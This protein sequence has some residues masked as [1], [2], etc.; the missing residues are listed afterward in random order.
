MNLVLQ[1]VATA[2]AIVFVVAVIGKV[3]AWASWTSLVRRFPARWPLIQTIRFGVPA[4]EAAVVVGLFTGAP[5]SLFGAA[6]LLV[7][8]A[9]GVA[10][11][12]SVIGHEKCNCFGAAM[13]AQ[14]GPALM[15]RNV[16]MAVA[17]ASFGAVAI[18]DG[19]TTRPSFGE[20]ICGVLVAT[21]LLLVGEYRRFSG[22]TAH[23]RI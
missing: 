22:T 23:E 14:L 7:V 3:D 20:A 18:R 2:F 21:F 1:A 5:Y 4:L 19:F 12:S 17:A 10:D 9:I 11:L 8:F 15:L 16:L 6:A 13:P